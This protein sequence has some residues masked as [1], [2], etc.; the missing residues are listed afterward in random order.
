MKMG[1][2]LSQL[3][4]DVKSQKTRTFLT[5]FGIFW[6]TVSIILLMA[7]GEGLR[8]QMIKNMRGM[9]EGIGVLWGSRTS[10][11]FEGMGKGRPIQLREE[12]AELLKKNIRGIQ[13][14]SPEYYRSSIEFRFGK[15]TYLSGVSGVIPEF[16]TI[17]NIIPDR[18][19]RFLNPM[20]IA[21]KRR[22]VFI[23][24]TLKKELFKDEEAV[25]QYVFIQNVP[26]LVVGVLRKKT[27][28]SNYYGMDEYW[29]YIPAS[30]HAA[31]F[32]Q[33]Y[34]SNI[35]YKLADPRLS[36]TVQKEVYEVLGK[37]FRFDP[38]DKEALSIWDTTE[39]EKFFIY[40][41]LGFEIFLGI[42][43]SFT[44]IVGAI[45]LSNIMNFVVEDR[46][47]EIGIKM[48]LGA[49]KKFILSQFLLET[50]I[51]VGIGGFIGFGIS[52]AIIT[53]FPRN[54]EEYVG[55]PVLS[56][57]I[58]LVTILVLGA[59]GVWAGYNPARRAAELNP[60]QALKD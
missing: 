58:G 39:F 49:K 37:K 43:G 52:Y 9:G 34:L 19:S 11:A 60:V 20:D 17:R 15:E 40:F 46:R 54:F 13:L 3:A 16:T 55:I 8:R 5:I 50:M 21:Q 59:T 2:V 32:G 6:G 45:G 41:F 56:I 51:L 22:V 12:D 26:F 48:A 27:Q 28:N 33:A 35:V 30:T 1:M 25:G 7:F 47:K 29:A 31:M 18:G 23:G 10:K 44:L 53:A 36:E 57:P 24:N 14:I 38:A 4:K 42:V